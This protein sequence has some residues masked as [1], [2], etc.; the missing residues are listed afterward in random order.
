MTA[1]SVLTGVGRGR[2]PGVK[3]RILEAA[4]QEFAALGY[5]RSSLRSITTRSGATKPMIYYHF[6][7][8][9]G[10]YAAVVN[11]ELSRLEHDLLGKVAHDG[12]TLARLETFARTYLSCFLND[13][14]GLALG[15]RELPTLPAPVFA[16]ITRDHAQLVVAVLKQILRDGELRGDLRPHDVDN[17][18]RAIIGILHYYI[19]GAGLDDGAAIEAAVRQV[20]HYYAVGL[21]SDT[22]LVRRP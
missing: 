8:K 20:V 1:V 6:Q 12:D 19:R 9:D 10:L 14:P 18:S 13:F 5:H 4:I 21:L 2:P 22:A 17:C 16:E 3:E 15:L 11:H 7:G